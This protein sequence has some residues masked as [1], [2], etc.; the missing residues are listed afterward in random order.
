MCDN[1]DVVFN[2]EKFAELI[3]TECA[4]IAEEADDTMTNQGVASAR[5]FKEYFG[6]K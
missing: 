6:I 2:K 5:A 1:F 3:V 4:R